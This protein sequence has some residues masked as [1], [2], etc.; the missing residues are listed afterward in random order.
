MSATVEQ[1]G[2][3]ARCVSGSPDY[4]AWYEMYGDAAVNGGAAVTI[5]QTLHA[6]DSVTATVSVAASQWTLTVTDHTA[7]WSYAPPAITDAAPQGSSAEWVLER[8]TGTALADFGSVAVTGASATAGGQP[9]PI[10]AYPSVAT[11]ITDAA[12]S[13]LDAIGPLDQT[14]SSFTETWKAG[15]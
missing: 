9:G 6:G 11:Q 5:A 3:T 13:V 2:T 14:G 12:G 4:F 15:S 1:D 7:G 10:S 8:P